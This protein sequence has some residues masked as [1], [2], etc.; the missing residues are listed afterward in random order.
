MVKHEQA[1]TLST[2]ANLEFVCED[3][4]IGGGFLTARLWA[5]LEDRQQRNCSGIDFIA[6]AR[7][8]AQEQARENAHQN[9]HYND[10]GARSHPMV[11]H[12]QKDHIIS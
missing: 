7:Y 8:T 6:F 1:A 3:S 10:W 12:P 2:S 5:R 4:I 9:V 11:A